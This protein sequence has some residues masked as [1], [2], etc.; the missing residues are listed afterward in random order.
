[1]LVPQISRFCIIHCSI[2]LTCSLLPNNTSKRWMIKKNHYL[3]S[4]KCIDKC[5][6]RGSMQVHIKQ[7]LRSYIRLKS[8]IIKANMTHCC[9]TSQLALIVI[10]YIT[11]KKEQLCLK[12]SK[13]GRTSQYLSECIFNNFFS[14]YSSIK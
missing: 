13:I 4:R 2:T 8:R 9:I 12:P 14:T 11:N 6:I 7:I 3:Q 10:I 5:N 1:M